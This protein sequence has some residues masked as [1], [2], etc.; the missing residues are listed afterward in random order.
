V[1]YFDWNDEKNV[2]LLKTRGVTFEDV[3][4]AIEGG[5]LLD[6]LRHPNAKKYP[7][8]FIL[9][10]LIGGT[11]YAVPCVEDENKVFMKTVIPDRKATQRYLKRQRHEEK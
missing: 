3:V 6:R 1:K 5:D 11:V 10:V 4:M 7:N 2:H 9:Y 8:Q